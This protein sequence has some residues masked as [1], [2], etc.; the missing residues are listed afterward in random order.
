MQG[1]MDSGVFV[2]VSLED[3]ENRLIILRLTGSRLEHKAY[4]LAV[5]A[6]GTSCH[7]LAKIKLILTS[8]PG[9]LPHPS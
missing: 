3:V 7:L 2:N 4:I 5:K 8:L 1:L 6:A 9:A